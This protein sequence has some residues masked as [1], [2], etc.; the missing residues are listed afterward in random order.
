[1][2]TLQGVAKRFGSRIVFDGV[3]L[4]VGAETLSDSL[5]AEHWIAAAA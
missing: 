5:E 4:E 2:L 1:M 3:S